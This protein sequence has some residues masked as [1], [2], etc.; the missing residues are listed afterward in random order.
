[1]GHGQMSE[2]T[3]KGKPEPDLDHLK[4]AIEQRAEIQRTLL[5]LYG[6]ARH[7]DPRHFPSVALFDN[8]IAAAFSL[9]RA[10]FLADKPRGTL[11][12]HAAQV[13]FLEKVIAT[14]AITFS[15]DVA[16]SPWSVNFY[17]Q[18]A[19]H[20]LTRAVKIATEYFDF[21]DEWTITAFLEV[22]GEEHASFTRYQWE[23]Q[24]VALRR[25]FN[26]IAPT[27]FLLPELP[28][29]SDTGGVLITWED[30]VTKPGAPEE[31]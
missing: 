11:R 15:D 27:A 16:A 18:N 30:L 21:K 7:N 10:A 12:I 8:C 6:Y 24:H 17:L 26:L 1:M 5:A 13:Q 20:R 14:N 29:P 2:S 23:C 31:E 4:W 3:K 19:H 9:W 22:V 28:M 25:L